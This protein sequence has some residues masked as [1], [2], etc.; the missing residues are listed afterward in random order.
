MLFLVYYL[1]STN[2][3]IAIISLSIILVNKAGEFFSVQKSGSLNFDKYL[4]LDE[5][6][7]TYLTDLVV[8]IK[9]IKSFATEKFELERM[10]RAKREIY[11]LFINIYFTLHN[12][13][14]SLSTLETISFYIT[15][16]V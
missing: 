10:K 5:K 14:M 6:F 2:F 1:I 4:K 9:L 3:K 7:S 12:L 8:N 11:N 16:E 13:A 15:Q